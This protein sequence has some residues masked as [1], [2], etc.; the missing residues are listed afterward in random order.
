MAHF[1]Q[2]S[3]FIGRPQFIWQTL[4]QEGERRQEAVCFLHKATI[5]PVSVTSIVN[6]VVYEVICQVYSFQVSSS[7][8]FTLVEWICC[9][10][11][12]HHVNTFSTVSTIIAYEEKKVETPLC[13]DILPCKT[14]TYKFTYKQLPN[15][16]IEWLI[17]VITLFVL[18][19]DLQAIISFQCVL[20]CI[21]KCLVFPPRLLIMKAGQMCFL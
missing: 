21:N 20:P 8:L 19:K 18:L 17:S 9:F 6:V 12:T 1:I 10:F 5:I 2:L 3:V 7:P 13:Y 14:L 4:L 15:F 11:F 16:K